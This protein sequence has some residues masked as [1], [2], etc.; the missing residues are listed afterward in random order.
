MERFVTYEK[1]L[2][3]IECMSEA[4]FREF[5]A[6]DR[7]DECNDW[8]EYVWQFAPDKEAAIAQHDEKHDEWQ[9]NPNSDTY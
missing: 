9:E 5:K 4:E 8:H 3:V 7:A 2:H 1:E 6:S